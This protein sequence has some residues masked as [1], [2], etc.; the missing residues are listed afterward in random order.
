MKLLPGAGP[1]KSLRSRYCTEYWGI[2][3]SYSEKSTVTFRTLGLGLEDRVAIFPLGLAQEIGHYPVFEHIAEG[4]FIAR[5][6]QVSRNSRGPVLR[7]LH[8]VLWAFLGGV[9]FQ[10][11]VDKQRRSAVVGHRRA[12][13]VG[14]VDQGHRAQFSGTCRVANSGLAY[15]GNRVLGQ[16]LVDPEPLPWDRGASGWRETVHGPGH[17]GKRG[18]REGW[19]R[20]LCI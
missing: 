5:V 17:P 6:P 16:P 9:M 4:S 2:L 1:G 12:G 18:C 10:E 15:D 20:R 11:V 13:T 19:R 14:P 8:Q 3:D 7:L